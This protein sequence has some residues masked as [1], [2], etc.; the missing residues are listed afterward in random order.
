MELLQLRRGGRVWIIYNCSSGVIT[1]TYK[2]ITMDTAF[3][4]ITKVVFPLDS[5]RRIRT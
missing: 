2:A 5:L 4:W 1:N 3:S